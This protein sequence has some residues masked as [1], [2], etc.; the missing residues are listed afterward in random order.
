MLKPGVLKYDIGVEFHNGK[1]LSAEDVVDSLNHHIAEESSS[2]AKGILSGIS[3]VKADG[4]STVLV[5]LSS[6]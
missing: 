2:A 6:W 4:A 3:T 5:D 1:T